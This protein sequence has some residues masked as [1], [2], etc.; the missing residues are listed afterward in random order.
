[1]VLLDGIEQ[2]YLAEAQLL[3]GQLVARADEP[4]ELARRFDRSPS[5][6]SRR[7]A[8]VQTLPE[9]VQEHI[10]QGRIPVRAADSVFQ[11]L[12][13]EENMFKEVELTTLLRKS[14]TLDLF[15]VTIRGQEAAERQKVEGSLPLP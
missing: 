2:G 10:R 4:G 8:M 6:V 9:S 7:L 15:E 11:K 14:M 3:V 12:T 13:A 5:W 1:M